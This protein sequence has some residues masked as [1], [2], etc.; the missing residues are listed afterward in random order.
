M[1]GAP[2]V[3]LAFIV[4]ASAASAASSAALGCASG[5]AP[6]A[7]TEEPQITAPEAAALAFASPARWHYHPAAPEAAET[8][9]KLP[10]GGCALT[11]E[12]GQRWTISQ[13]KGAEPRGTARGERGAQ[14]TSSGRRSPSAQPPQAAAGDP[15][16]DQPCLGRAQAAS[17]LAPEELTGIIRRSSGSWLFVA[18]GGTLYESGSA[19]G[20]FTRVIQ[21]PEPL[22]SVSGAGSTLLGA[23]IDGKLFVYRD[24][25][26]WQPV[27]SMTSRIAD[28]AVAEGGR[29]LALATP[30]ALFTTEDGGATW[31]PSP[32]G[33]VGAHHVGVTAAGDLA[34]QGLTESITWDPRRAAPFSFTAAPITERRIE[35]DA[36]VSPAPSATAVTYKRAAIDG[37]RYYEV[38][39]RDEGDEGWMLS[40]GKLGGSLEQRPIPATE[41]CGSMKLGA[42]GKQIVTACVRA[43]GDSIIAR[44]R[45]SEDGGDTWGDPLTLETL[46][47]D[48]VNIAV[49]PDGAALLVGVCKQPDAGSACKPGAPL[50]LRPEGRRR[51]VATVTEALA[52]EGA[53]SLP[54]FS[55]D[56]RS[57]YFL[58]QRI[59]DRRIALFVSHDGGE[60]F[61]ER[62]LK[63]VA[64]EKPEGDPPSDPDRGADEEGEDRRDG[65]EVNE[66]SSLQPGEDGAVGMVLM[67][68]DGI[69]YLTA[70]EDGRVIRAGTPPAPGAIIAGYGRRVVSIS[71]GE[72]DREGAPDG[73]SI[74]AWE[75]LDG[76]GSWTEITGTRA[77]K[78]D[79]FRSTPIIACGGGGCLFG[80][81]IARV[82]WGGQAEAPAEPPVKALPTSEQALRTP[83]VCEL[84]ASS[85]WTRID[86]VVKPGWGAPDM[87]EAMRG[88]SVWSVLTHDRQSGA[89]S[90][91][92]AMLPE[93]APASGPQPKPGPEPEARVI[94]RPLF[95]RA[96]K[97]VRTALSISRQIEGYAAARV[98]FAVDAKGN[99]KLG[100]PMR[101]VEIAWENWND[102]T[103]GRV[104]LKDAG[105]FELGDVK[106]E[107]NDLYDA[108][109][110]SVTLRGIFVQPHSP[111]SRSTA[112]YFIDPSGKTQRFDYPSWPERSFG[113]QLS[114]KAEAV[115]ADGQLVAVGMEPSTSRQPVSTLLL[116]RRDASGWTTTT[117]AVAPRPSDPSDLSIDTSWTYSGRSIGVTVLASDAKRSRAWSTF[118]AFR[119]DGSLGPVV[120]LPTPFNVKGPPRPCAAADRASTP[121]LEASLFLGGDVAFPGTR[122][123][124]LITERAAAASSSA[125]A[126]ARPMIL[127]TSGMILHGTPSSSCVAAWDTDDIGRPAPDAQLAAIIPGDLTH[128]WLFRPAPPD[129]APA[130]PSVASAD[131]PDRD[132]RRATSI[133]YRPMTCRFDPSAAVP[134][135]VLSEPGAT[136][137]APPR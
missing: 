120:P 113:R 127:L 26:G 112:M 121:R 95:G 132:A 44:I 23:T 117:T 32:L 106:T 28:V 69:V 89:V 30:E 17:S 81:T 2:T 66:E 86:N 46:A 80:E 52:L 116:A 96:P 29:A 79:F 11:A 61:S 24:A 41:D 47:T 73:E 102:E 57:A 12:G 111:S 16:R 125:T 7:R 82:G 45:R 68:E 74:H 3:R 43:M 13:V 27:S 64:T 5:A 137:Q 99:V 90:A 134:S 58:G 108:A 130:R 124:V 76:A 20:P 60:S 91:V 25:E 114:I 98:R 118:Q 87:N 93:A 65:Y 100:V 77:L 21:P 101:D 59:K 51:M 54:A 35:L 119:G 50:L 37:D 19:L 84:D 104:T 122:H 42:N 18:A 9:I 129:A 133:E 53:A 103:S 70:D 4:A 55:V 33:P 107:H 136:R 10:D 63:E 115:A 92:S 109:L 31:K 22:A 110:L 39:H 1:R 131:Q 8:W 105:P 85:R 62:P 49:A 34:A 94:T 14:S 128:A 36:S 40:R 88:R 72:V 123:P 78:R 48:D 6:R 71:V 135:A 83:I 56:G 15:S 38:N 97:G 75:S 67:G 126:A